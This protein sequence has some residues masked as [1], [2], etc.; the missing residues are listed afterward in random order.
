MKKRSFTLIELLIVVAI[1]GILAAI[2]VPNFLNA[3]VRAKIARVQSDQRAVA[4]ACENYKIDQNAYPYPQSNL[5]YVGAIPELTTPVSYLSSLQ[6]HDPFNTE[7]M[8]EAGVLNIGAEF[9]T[10]VWGNYRGEWGTW[11]AG[12]NGA[13]VSQM[14]NGFSINSAGPDHSFSRAMHIPLERKFNKPVTGIIYNP[15]N[16]LNSAGDLIRYGGE[17]AGTGP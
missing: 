16:G 15:S 1:I 11:W 2:A 12:S 4:T 6:L 17:T 10:Y 8:G 5:R 3:Q 7:K 14:P 13:A 9:S